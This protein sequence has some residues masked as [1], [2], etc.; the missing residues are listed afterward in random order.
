M[1]TPPIP[2]PQ[3][4]VA[5]GEFISCL[6]IAFETR[7]HGFVFRRRGNRSQVGFS[8]SS[9]AVTLRR[10]VMQSSRSDLTPQQRQTQPSRAHLLE[11]GRRSAAS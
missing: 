2:P 1:L 6:F 3:V 5:V 4:T 8:A 11:R 7:F 9:R 10:P